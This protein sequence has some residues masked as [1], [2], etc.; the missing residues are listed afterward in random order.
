MIYS[1]GYLIY[2]DTDEHLRAKIA[3]DEGAPWSWDSWWEN[4]E[5]PRQSGQVTLKVTVARNQRYNSKL[6][7]RQPCV[8]PAVSLRGIQTVTE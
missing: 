4:Q 5:S 1:Y 6:D 8:Q 2:S 7:S 3:W